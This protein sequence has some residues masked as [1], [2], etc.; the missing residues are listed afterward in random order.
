MMRCVTTIFFVIALLGRIPT[1]A[2]EPPPKAKPA[3][4]SQVEL[5]LQTA[6][7]ATVE[8]LMYL[9]KG[10]EQQQP[11]PLMLFLHG[12]GESHGPLSLVAKW[13]PPMF[14]ARGDDLPFI[15][16]SPQCP[17]D[18]S[19]AKPSQQSRLVELLDTIVDQYNVDEAQIYLTGLS[20]GGYGSWRLAA[21]HPNRFAAVVPV[22]GGGDPNDAEKLK[23]LPIWVFHG[24]KDGA[25]PFKRSV[26]M[27]DAIQRAGSDSIL[28]TSLENVGHNCWSATYATPDLYA[29]LKKQRR[30]QP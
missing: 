1:N 8:Y 4:G 14:A 19:W 16:V 28:F 11:W 23:D 30:E 15:L 24:D 2:Q 5:S 20:M 18:D 7:A 27:V 26:E 13:G 10:Y 29:W 3:P 6:D 12:R 9:P 17:A 25:V 21:D 22:C